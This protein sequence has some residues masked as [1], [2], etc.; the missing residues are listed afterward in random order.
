MW[1]WRLVQFIKVQIRQDLALDV[2]AAPADRSL[3]ALPPLAATPVLPVAR[4]AAKPSL[5]QQTPQAPV[6]ISSKTI[7]FPSTPSGET[8]GMEWNMLYIYHIVKCCSV[9]ETQTLCCSCAAE[10]QLEVQ[11]GEEEVRWYLSSFAPPY[12]KV[13]FQLWFSFCQFLR[14]CF[15]LIYIY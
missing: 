13:P 8:S 11:N 15:C 1:C 6:E 7:I 3:S 14:F 10:A 12:V 4:L 5:P 2:S 9:C